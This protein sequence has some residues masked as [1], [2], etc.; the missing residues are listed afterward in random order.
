MGGMAHA[1]TACSADG[2]GMELLRSL[3]RRLSAEQG[4]FTLIELVVVLEII[5]I[6]TAIAVPSYLQY[7]DKAYKGAASSN[8]KT[9]VIAAGLY[10][11][12]NYPGSAH[13]P[14]PTVS[15]LDSGFA[16]MTMAELKTYDANLTQ[17]AYVN[18][19]G[20][21]AP[22]VT[23]RAPRDATHFCIYG[24]AGRWYAYQL[25]PTGAITTTTTASA[26]CT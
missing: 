17:N 7:R 23:V 22:G 6:L 20:I 10:Q 24:V 3:A 19:S 14:D 18:N 11:Q 8:V 1:P 16:G 5:A 9:V 26:V 25:N 15:L 4:G 12:D 2:L 21:D 13:D